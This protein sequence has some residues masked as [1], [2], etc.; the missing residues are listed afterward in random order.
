MEKLDVDRIQRL[1]AAGVSR[2][3]IAGA[4][5]I[6]EKAVR[7]ALRRSPASPAVA[8]FQERQKALEEAGDRLAEVLQE[9]IMR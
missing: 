9:E 7:W 4:L 2:R 3:E 8:E 1:A 6:D 5:G